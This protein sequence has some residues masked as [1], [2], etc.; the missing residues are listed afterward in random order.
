M[1]MPAAYA[2]EILPVARIR[3]RRHGAGVLLDQG[4]V[5]PAL[6]RS[7]RAFVPAAIAGWQRLD[8]VAQPSHCPNAARPLA[9]ARSNTV[10]CAFA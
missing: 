9:L 3:K 10:C 7:A 8:A 1:I 2:R 4:A 5:A 6:A